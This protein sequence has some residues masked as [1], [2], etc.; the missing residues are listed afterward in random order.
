MTVLRPGST[1]HLAGD[2]PAVV[3]GVCLRKDGVTYEVAWWQNGTRHTAWVH[4]FEL[5]GE[6]RAEIGFR[7]GP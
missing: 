4:P 1:V 3:L 6:E 7:E 2:V 5:E